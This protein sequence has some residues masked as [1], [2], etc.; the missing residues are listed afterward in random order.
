MKLRALIRRNADGV[1]RWSL[2]K[3][4]PDYGPGV[5]SLGVVMGDWRENNYSCD[6]NR[7]LQFEWA[8]DGS[9][10][11]E[12]IDCGDDVLYSVLRFDA[13]R[14]GQHLYNPILTP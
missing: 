8:A 5:D 4:V 14:V 10:R 7:H 9:G 3:T 2:W 11:E 1:E 13:Q 12:D 6:C